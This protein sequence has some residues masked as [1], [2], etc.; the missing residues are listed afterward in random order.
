[1]GQKSRPRKGSAKQF[2]K[3]ICRAIRPEPLLSLVKGISGGWEEAPGR[4]H[5]TGGDLRRRRGVA[6]GGQRAEGGGG[7]ADAR[8]PSAEK[9]R[10]RGLGGRR[11]PCRPT[12]GT[13]GHQNVH[14]GAAI[15]SD[16][17]I[18]LNRRLRPAARKGLSKTKKVSVEVIMTTMPTATM[19]PYNSS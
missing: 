3:E 5:R 2:L 4:R 6:P 7:R 14:R 9:N 15:R 10:D 19:T 17:T 11:Q 13:P 16:C 8:E 18:A 12:C 1:M